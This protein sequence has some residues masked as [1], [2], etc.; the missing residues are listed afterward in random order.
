MRARGV[1]SAR[2]EKVAVVGSGVSIAA[3]KNTPAASWKGLLT[4]GRK[5][6]QERFT[7]ALPPGWGDSMRE[8]VNS[9]DLDEMLLAAEMIERKLGGPQGTFSSLIE[10]ALAL[11][12][13][14]TRSSMC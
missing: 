3:T 5:H 9:G 11:E 12:L 8:H 6:C 7:A 2:K 13:K 10:N 4:L 14:T 1:V